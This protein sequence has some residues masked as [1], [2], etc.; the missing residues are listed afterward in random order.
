MSGIPPDVMETLM[1]LIDIELGRRERLQQSPRVVE[2]ETS[3][4]A[5]AKITETNRGP[6][7]K[8]MLDALA[9]PRNDPVLK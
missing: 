2:R 3:S 7:A 4:P 8:K 9:M 1:V 6:Q 5:Q